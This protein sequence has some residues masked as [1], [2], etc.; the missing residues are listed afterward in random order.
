MT[1][2]G[3]AERGSH[4]GTKTPRK[5][6]IIIIF[7]SLCLGGESFAGFRMAEFGVAGRDS[8]KGTKTPRKIFIIIFASLC[9]GGESFVLKCIQFT[10]SIRDP[11]KGG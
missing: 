11:N 2:L 4:K 5:I 1:E 10:N 6:F 8:H 7:A 3:Q 9:L